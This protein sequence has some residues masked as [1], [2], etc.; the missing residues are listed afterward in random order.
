MFDMTGYAVLKRLIDSV[1]A[2]EDKLMPNEFETFR[3]L[4]AKY[5]EPA[6][7]DATDITCLEVILR[8]IEI[9]KGYRIDPRTDGGRVI[10]M[11]RVGRPKES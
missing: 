6:S 11:P 3:S 8:N 4:V 5:A 9:R 2:I 1:A 10:D 7:P